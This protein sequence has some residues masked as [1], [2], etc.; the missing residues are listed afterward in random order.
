M[1]PCTGVI[2]SF[3]IK[4]RLKNCQNQLNNSSFSQI[5]QECQESLF[6]GKIHFQQNSKEGLKYSKSKVL[7]R[8]VIQSFLVYIL[9]IIIKNRSKTER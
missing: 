9:L 8:Y 5:E 4:R 2:E 6:Q 7:E 3:Q 1:T